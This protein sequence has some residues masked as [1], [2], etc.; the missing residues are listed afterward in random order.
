MKFNTEV[1][2]G[3]G[4]DYVKLKAGG[5]VTGVLRGELHEY[6]VVWVGGKSVLCTTPGAG[7]FRFKVNLVV[8]E[9]GA[10]VSKILEQGAQVYTQL[11]ALQ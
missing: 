6:E 9:N 1:G 5:S 3:D 4:G 11:K 10:Y 7:K 2:S 8:T